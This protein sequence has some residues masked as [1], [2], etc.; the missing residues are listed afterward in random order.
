MNGQQFRIK[1]D[2]QRALRQS[3]LDVH[4]EAEANGWITVLDPS[5][6]KHASAMRWI[7]GDQGR[8]F[9]ELRS[10][11]ALE[12]VTNHADTGFTG[13]A[14]KLTEVLKR[15]PPGMVVFI[16]YPGQQCFRPHLD[17]EV[18]FAHQTKARVYTHANDKDFKEHFDQEA[19][20]VNRMVQRG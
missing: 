16:F 8:R 19:D 6:E 13:N 20:R 18:V 9:I 5:V 15:T 3:C 14:V 4:C 17:R 1:L 12:Y 7:K 11:D 2:A 10:E